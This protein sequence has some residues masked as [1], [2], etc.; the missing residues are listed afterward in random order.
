[1]KRHKDVGMLL[2]FFGFG[3]SFLSR[4]HQVQAHCCDK[5]RRTWMPSFKVAII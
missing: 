3:F 5:K 4:V 2:G 1:M